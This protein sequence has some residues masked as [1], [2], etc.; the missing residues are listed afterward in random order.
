MALQLM[1]RSLQAQTVQGTLDAV[2]DPTCEVAGWARD[3]T[4]PNPIQVSIYRDGDAASGTFIAMFV[5]D[6]LRTDLPYP[7]QNHGFD[8]T[9]ATNPL[10]ADGNSHTI[11]A[12][13][14]TANGATGP[15]NGN[16]KTIQCASI[17]TTLSTN[18]KD[19]GASGD[20][21]TDDSNAIQAALNAT[22]P[23]GTVLIPVG[24]Y[25]IAT[26]HG[27]AGNF[28]ANTCGI[29]P[30]SQEQTGLMITKP[31]TITGAGR[32]TIL[33]LA[34]NVK[35]D[36]IFIAAPNT[37]I[38]KLVLDGN[39]AQ[40][41][42][43]DP[44]SGQPYSYPCGLVVAGLIN[45][46][47]PAT[48]TD[49]IVDVES[50]N[51]IEDGMGMFE[52]PNFTVE[53][54][55]VH[56]NGGYGINPTYGNAAGGS[57]I[58]FSGGANQTGR[59]NVTIG[60]TNGPTVGFGS[61]GVNLSYNVSIG[62]LNAGL[63]LGTSSASVPYAQPDSNFVV[64]HN[65]AEQNGSGVWVVGAQNGGFSNNYVVNN[66]FDGIQ[67]N[68][69]GAQWPAS[70]N[71]QVLNNVIAR[72]PRAGIYVLNRSTG[73]VL[74]SND[75]E[76]N[77]SSLDAQVV[78]DPSASASSVNANWMTVNTVTYTPPP[79]NP[80]A[81][82]I[83]GIVNAASEQPGG[84]SPGELLAVYGSNLGPS[85]LM[86]AAANSDGRFER[87]LSGTRVLFDGVP[88]AMWYTSAV[89]VAAIAPYY[90]YWKDSTSVQ[91]EYNGVKSNAVTVPIQQSQPAVFTL[92]ASG[93]GPGAI[94]NQD[95]SV[96][97]AANPAARGSVVILYATGEGQTDPAGVDGLLANVSP[98]PQ[99]RLPVSATIGGLNAEVLYA[100]AAPTF[101]AG[102]MQINATIPTTAPLGPTVP[103]QISVG[104]TTS[105][106][107]VT[108]AV[109]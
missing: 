36:I 32:G 17:G 105:P 79:T 70:I 6:V 83:A 46:H 1:D 62:N 63:I 87:I 58:S 72:N 104:N 91:V 107:G 44:S 75:I 65:G 59:D 12:Y 90:I 53:S 85:K 25:I 57:A 61:V 51:A 60:N 99:P 38:E 66:L 95:Y 108:L 68:D 55:Y 40:R 34:S 10:L 29:D 73:L 41:I 98:L 80:Q 103:I 43:I 13:G 100:G 52:T 49:V 97:S 7:D 48:G 8:Q 15:L 101:V 28:G 84:I 96:N 74:Q 109:K 16:G 47:S 18:V 21:V 50:R 3:P 20:G 22:L 31:V 9:F 76:N 30:N 19:Y 45:G 35:L 78:I 54:V 71:W 67:F 4:N 88:A 39:G 106:V 5:A 42:R 102:A 89:Q 64:T 23:G 93:R 77:A 81:P 2:T 11:Y 86:S 82:A 24:T 26:S 27:Q 92:N 33:M 94:L 56:N 37:T 69:K 14:L